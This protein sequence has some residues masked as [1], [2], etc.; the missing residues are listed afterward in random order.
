MPV[1]TFRNESLCGL[2]CDMCTGFAAGK[3]NKV[4]SGAFCAGKGFEEAEG[5]SNGTEIGFE[6]GG[7]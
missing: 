7:L 3:W 4:L 1:Q 5:I 2:M 6:Y